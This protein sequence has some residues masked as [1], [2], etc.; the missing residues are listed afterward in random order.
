MKTTFIA[1]TFAVIVMASI[2][3]Q[4]AG[5]ES[6]AQ[7]H[8]R[9][10]W[11]HDA[12]FGLFIH[13]GVY[14][15]PAGT[16]QGQ[17][18]PKNGEWIMYHGKI[19]VKEYK[20]FARQFNPVKYDPEAWVALAEEAG[21]KY[22]VIT[23]KHH[24][25]FALFDSRASDWDVADA[26]PYGKDLLGP[27]A[28]AARRH[29]LK[30][31]LYYSQAAD[32]IHPGG[33]KRNYPEGGGWDDAQKG[34]FDLYLDTVAVPQ[35]TEILIRY[36]PD[37]LWWDE[38]HWMNKDRAGRLFALTALR[39][40][41]ITNSRLGGGYRGDT[42]TPEQYIPATGT[43]G[44]A[45][46]VSMTMNDTWGYK[47][48]DTNWKN[49]TELIRKLADIVSK[50]G[51]FLL[52]VGPTAEGEFPQASV[53]RLKEIGAWMKVNHEA[54]YGTTA[55]PFFKLPWGRCTKKLNENGATLYLH[56]FDWPENRELS[57]PGLKN[58]VTSARLLSSGETVKATSNAAGVMLS[59]PNRAPDSINSV[60]RVDIA[61]DLQVEGNMPSESAAG[62][63]FLP[64][65]MADIHNH[66]YSV[67]AVLTGRYEAAHISSWE[68]PEVRVDW[69]F[70]VKEGGAFQVEA[71]LVCV[72]KG[73]SLTV[74]SG[75]N[76][77]DARV[78]AAGNADTF[79]TVALGRIAVANS[80]NNVI[81]IIPDKNAWT[82]IR[83]KSIRLT[84]VQ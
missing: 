46:E 38:P 39:P 60:I 20:G 12:K 10:Q 83:L 30:F 49:T 6:E 77:L 22:L 74:K 23:S 24:D 50:G 47:S 81:Q 55:S 27:L 45:W 56:V 70:T 82:P 44:R 80:G 68:N 59:V 14:A 9:M 7:K 13:W 28:E 36:K 4:S 5:A 76:T 72:E 29:G 8:E 67:Q 32:W 26:T 61:G 33:A 3:Q 65:M 57:L 16:Y 42:S 43:P 31:G 48:Y 15:V 51:N 53:E 35:V 52:N 37:I 19:P 1:T 11:W 41:I 75:G 21:M 58:T 64:A 2:A 84:R 18:I 79:R 25:G 62:V 78:D 54:I 71:E 73:T 17:Q 69:M 63:I 66:G 34:S 40:G